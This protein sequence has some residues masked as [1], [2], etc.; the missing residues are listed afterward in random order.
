MGCDVVVLSGT[1]SKR[2][3]A[4]DLGANE[5]YATK[6]VEDYSKLGL[7]KP[8][9]HLLIS[10]SVAPDLLSDYYP[11]LAQNAKIFP[12]TVTSGNFSAVQQPTLSKGLQIIGSIL[13]SRHW[14]YVI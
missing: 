14:Q 11:I 12:L 4:M 6:G 5:F 2:K 13:A 9:D 7:E 3:E 10:T 1:D 8:L